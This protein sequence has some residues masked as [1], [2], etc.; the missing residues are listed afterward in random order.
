LRLINTYKYQK[1]ITQTIK[2]CNLI[3]NKEQT[4]YLTV[5]NPKPPTL[6]AQIKLHKDGNPIR[7]VIS[8]LHAPSYK[9]A[10]RLN[11]ILQQHLNLDNHYTAVN[12][13]TLAQDLTQLNINSKHR[14][15]TLDIKDLYVNISITETI[16]IT[17]TQLLKHNDPETTTQICTLLGVLLQQNYFIFQ[18]RIYQPEK[19][20]AMGS[21][22]SGTIA[23]VFL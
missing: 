20:V 18:E 3:F 16:D 14:L 10:K 4:K 19:G 2:Q 5:R 11:K 12:S 13:S 9:A 21:P 1:Q 8:N 15:I 7:P 17:T 22:I 6:K 23:E